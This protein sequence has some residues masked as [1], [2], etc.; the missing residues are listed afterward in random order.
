[1]KI[2]E[3]SSSV[4]GVASDKLAEEMSALLNQQG[5]Y[6]LL[7]VEDDGSITGLTREPREAEEFVMNLARTRIQPGANPTWHTV[8]WD[9]DMVVGVVEASAR[10][11]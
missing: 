10:R 5:G 3:S 8:K 2:R 9:E 6:I 7:G 4:T 11:A 1:M